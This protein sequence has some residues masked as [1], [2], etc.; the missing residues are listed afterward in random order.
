MNEKSCNAEVKSLQISGILGAFSLSFCRL[1]AAKP[2]VL[3]E[4]DGSPSISKSLIELYEHLLVPG[5]RA[6]FLNNV[7][8]AAET[9]DWTDLEQ[10]YINWGKFGWVCTHKIGMEVWDVC[11][12]TQAEADKKILKKYHTSELREDILETYKHT[13]NLAL[14]SEAAKCFEQRYYRACASLLCSLIDAALIQQQSLLKFNN[15]KTG[16]GAIERL[17]QVKSQRENYT[18]AG[19]FYFELLNCIS[20]LNMLFEPA[21][22]F[23]QEPDGINR[24]Y[25]LHGICKRKVLRKDC[26]KLFIAY[27]Q[28]FKL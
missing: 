8:I 2:R 24:N 22:G 11:P 15:I 5:N 25:L 23:V 4:L 18:R 16:V 9:T 6:S 26:I 27:R 19:L 14:F 12:A 13:P 1:I 28:L 7:E 21:N 3:L 20:F 10:S 17:N